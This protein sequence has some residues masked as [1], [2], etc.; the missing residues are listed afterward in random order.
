MQLVGR[1]RRLEDLQFSLG[2][3]P[4]HDAYATDATITEPDVTN[5]TNSRWP[6]Y[7]PLAIELGVCTVF[8][9]PLHVGVETVSVLILYQDTV[10]MLTDEQNAD[11]RELAGCVRR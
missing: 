10:G 5:M 7:T 1:V 6:S 8:A 11:G 2:E 3:G 4:S 9:F